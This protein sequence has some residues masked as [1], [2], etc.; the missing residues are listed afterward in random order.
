MVETALPKVGERSWFGLVAE[1]ACVPAAMDD[2]VARSIDDKDER[3]R[4]GSQD[5][6]ALTL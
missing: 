2:S 1:R 5:R 4:V 3:V 6:D